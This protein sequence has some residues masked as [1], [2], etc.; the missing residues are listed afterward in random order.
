MYSL[1]AYGEM[2][3]D[4]IRRQAYVDAMERVIRPGCV[5]LEIGTGPGVF[6][7]HAARLGAR[8][9]YA[10]ETSDAIEVGRQLA[11]ANGLSD[12]VEFLQGLS[13]DL[14]LP[15]K[16][17]VVLSDLR[18]LLPLFRNH[19]ESIV[20]ARQR[21]LAPG[22]Q[23]I[24]QEDSLWV[25][26]VS[27]ED[28]YLKLVR[29]WREHGLDLDLSIPLGLVTNSM[30]KGTFEAEQCLVE[31]RTWAR[32]DYRRIE[33]G[34]RVAGRVSWVADRAG[35]AHGLAVWFDTKLTAG[36]GFSNA[37][38]RQELIYGRSFL[39]F[40]RPIELQPEDRID[41][42]L[43]AVLVGEDYVWRWTTAI[44]S[45][46]GARLRFE[47]SSFD[48]VPLSP[49]TL[50]KR[51]AGYTPKLSEDGEVTRFVLDRMDARTSLETIARDLQATYPARF[52]TWRDALTRV[53]QLA[54]RHS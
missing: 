39:P 23:L 37:P 49:V 17:D 7:L 19:L 12:R 54:V 15:E 2:I 5:V 9:V 14:D 21:L 38:G 48:G 42:D 35:R 46:S 11:A 27:A 41:V 29:G 36:I 16:A 51:A 4:R 30:C 13:T 10:I 26:V 45:S 44:E 50:H 32:L 31:P 1:A 24:P 20:D 47:Q 28:L 8:K 52:T 34:S 25:S 3:A 53:G 43:A 18:G 40:Q 33:T 6:A 22:G